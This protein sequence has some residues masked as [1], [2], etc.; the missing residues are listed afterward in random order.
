MKPH[1]KLEQLNPLVSA[2]VD[3]LAEKKG[4]DIRLLD[5]GDLVGY[6]DLLVI[7]GGQSTTQVQA[8]VGSIEKAVHGRWRP[9]YVN[10]STDNSWW[11]L[12]FVD[13][14]V[15]VFLQDA[16]IQYDLES[17]WGDAP[18]GWDAVG[19]KPPKPSEGNG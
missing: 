11:I 10:R 12:D 13:V 6:A 5:V 4:E 7:V 15:H 19:I 1:A 2:V 3:A 18:D 14:V 17:L 9:T 16:R 8:L